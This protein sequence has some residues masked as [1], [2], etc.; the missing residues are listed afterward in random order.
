MCESPRT[1]PGQIDVLENKKKW[2]FCLFKEINS[3]LFISKHA[4][5]R[6]QTN[7]LYINQDVY[8]YDLQYKLSG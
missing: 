8:K 6:T 5:C 4:Y 3:F 1:D 7:A 2:V